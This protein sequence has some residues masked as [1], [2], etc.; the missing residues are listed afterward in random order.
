MPLPSRHLAAVLRPLLQQLLMA[1][2]GAAPLE[3]EA[4]MADVRQ[5]SCANA[6]KQLAMLVVARHMEAGEV[7]GL[8]ALFQALDE[9]AAGTI[10]MAQLQDAMRHMGK[11][12][13]VCGWVGGWGWGGGWGGGG[14]AARRG[15]ICAPGPPLGNRRA[16]GCTK[17]TRPLRLTCRAAPPAPARPAGGRAGA[18]AAAGG[19]GSQAPRRDRV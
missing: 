17:H 5:F 8:R 2:E 15:A 9:E 7:E 3:L 14:G 4:W 19:A 16:G 11:Q 1:G 12:V 6:F 18:A 10:S 13:C